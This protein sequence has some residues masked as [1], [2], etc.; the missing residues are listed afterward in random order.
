MIEE[1]ELLVLLL[2]GTFLNTLLFDAVVLPSILGCCCIEAC[3]AI[4]PTFAT[5]KSTATKNTTRIGAFVNSSWFI[6]FLLSHA[7]FKILYSNIGQTLAIQGQTFQNLS[8]PVMSTT[9]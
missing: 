1:V 4:I 8:L 7:I 6:C 9:G 3:P 5:A 2:A